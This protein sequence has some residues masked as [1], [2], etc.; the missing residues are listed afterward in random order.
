MGRNKK[1]TEERNKMIAGFI[2]ATS[3]IIREEGVSAVSIRKVAAKTG[4]S[5]AMIYLYFKDINELIAI[6]SIG[7]LKDY[8]AEIAANADTISDPREVYFNTWEVFCRHSFNNPAVFLSLFYR[9]SSSDF[10]EI[11]RKYYTAF[12][13]ELNNISGPMLFML[14]AGN[15]ADRNR[16]VLT[17]YARQMGLTHEQT[18]LLNDITVSYHESVLRTVAEADLSEEQRDAELKRFMR[19]LHFLTERNEHAERN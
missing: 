7:C 3:D 19:G 6:S 1:T 2:E 10:D 8:V 16:T 15:E 14:L 12:P 11:V 5:T 17:P 9:N 13:N 4:Y 18:D